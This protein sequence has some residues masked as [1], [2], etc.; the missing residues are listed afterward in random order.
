VRITDFTLLVFETAL[1]ARGCGRILDE[2][3]AAPRLT[4]AE[5]PALERRR[6]LES[7]SP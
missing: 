1:V 2:A 7:L 4:P 3:R 5:G 6:V